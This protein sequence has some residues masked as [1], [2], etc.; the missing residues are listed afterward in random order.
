MV[1]HLETLVDAR[2]ILRGNE[3]CDIRSYIREETYQIGV[4]RLG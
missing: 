2:E 3:L 1:S 4:P